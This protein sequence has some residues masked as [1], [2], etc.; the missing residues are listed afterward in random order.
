MK[1]PYIS[2]Y[3]VEG[4]FFEEIRSKNQLPKLIDVLINKENPVSVGLSKNHTFPTLHLNKTWTN[5]EYMLSGI[6]SN[7]DWALHYCDMATSIPHQSNLCG[8]Y[9]T[10]AQLIRNLDYLYWYIHTLFLPKGQHRID[11]QSVS[12]RNKIREMMA[13]EDIFLLDIPSAEVS[14]PTQ[15]IS[16][17]SLE[18][19]MSLIKNEI[20]SYMEACRWDVPRYYDWKGKQFTKQNLQTTFIRYK[21]LIDLQTKS[22]YCL[23]EH[24]QLVSLNNVMMVVMK[25]GLPSYFD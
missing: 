24:H 17:E 4:G 7:Q 13:K 25:G 8:L 18:K 23:D 3:V 1:H 10:S 15:I 20:D 21:A 19:A 14:Y 2:V 6:T 16:L 5:I 22:C 12:Y 9:L 11:W